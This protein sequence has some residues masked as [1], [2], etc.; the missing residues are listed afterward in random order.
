MRRVIRGLALVAVFLG[1]LTGA[2]ALVSRVDPFREVPTL[3]EKWA[4]WLQHKEE[5]DTL[6]IGT[7]RIYRG[8]KPS[9]FDQVTAAGGLPTHTFNFGVDAML[10]PEDAYVAGYILRNPP[11][12]LKWVFL[13]LGVFIED[14][15]DRAPDSV[16]SSHWHDWRR[17]W[18]CIR[19]NLWPKGKREK[20]QKW[21]RSE[22]GKPWPADVA[23]TH[24]RLFISKSLNLGRG[25]AA[26]EELMLGKGPKLALLGRDGDGYNA[27]ND[28]G[29]VSG[30][31]LTEY[32]QELKNRQQKPARLS[33]LKSYHQ[34]CF[35]DEVKV[36]R[37]ASAK[38]I[39]LIGPTTGPLRLRPAESSGVPLIDLCDVEAYPQLFAP[40]V[41]IDHAHVNDK[42]AQI[43][44]RMVAAQFLNI[45]KGLSPTATTAPSAPNSIPT[46]R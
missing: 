14:F 23:W 44:T 12:N 19:A 41:R 36:V 10:A 22:R 33:Q 13:E 11:K 3:R 15:E 26:L 8:L 30:E 4:H 24:F 21:F 31:A 38:P 27:Y 45:A 39:A 43:F 17:T 1:A 25:A 35:D 40:D 37:A 29:G 46:P 9:V 6:F 7:S 20:W 5:Y 16:R 18:L 2:A 42:G 28:R 32:L 34:Q